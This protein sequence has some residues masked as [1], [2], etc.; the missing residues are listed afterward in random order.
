MRVRLCHDLSI[1]GYSSRFNTHGL[2]EV[3]VNF[4]DGDSDSM[5]ISSLE[6]QL[7][8]GRWFHMSNAFVEREIISD[9]FNVCFAEPR[10]DVERQRGWFE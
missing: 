3:I 9:N 10:N 6:V 1:T 8:D 2:G 7:G 4:D 5:P